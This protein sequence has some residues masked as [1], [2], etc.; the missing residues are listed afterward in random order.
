[1]VVSLLLSFFPF[2]FSDLFCYAARVLLEHPSFFVFFFG[3]WC[4][5][6][7]KVVFF[8]R[9]SFVYL[10]GLGWIS[11]L[12]VKGGGICEKMAILGRLK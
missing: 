6:F 12:E 5:G 3:S 9:W 4:S 8:S 1:M 7:L 10:L 2:I 11:L